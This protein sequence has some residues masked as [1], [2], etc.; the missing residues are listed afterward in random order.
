[1]TKVDIEKSLLDPRD[2]RYIELEN[3][4]RVILISAKSDSDCED[5]EK[6]AAAALSINVGSFS[7]PEEAQGIAHFLEHSNL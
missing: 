6:E 4:T 1:M 3:G 5:E 7:D 2:H